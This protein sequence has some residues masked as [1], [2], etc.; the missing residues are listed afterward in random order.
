MGQSIIP[1]V[2]RRLTRAV[3]AALVGMAVTAASVAANEPSDWVLPEDDAGIRI[4]ALVPAPLADPLIAIPS[5]APSSSPQATATP[6]ATPSPTPNATPEPGHDGIGYDLSY[7]QCDDDYPEQF[8]FAIVGVNGGRVFNRNPCFGPGDEPSQLEWAG[9]DAE[10]YFN[11]GNPGPRISRYW[12]RGQDEPRACD[13]RAGRGANRD[14]TADCAFVYGWNAAEFAHD[15][16]LE[17]FIDLGWAED[18]T[19]QL[20]G[21]TTIWLDVEP[22]NSWRPDRSLNVATLEGAVAYLEAVGVERIGFY[23]T[24]RLW[25]RI[26]GG[27]DRF[28]DYPA[29]HAGARDRED[30]ERRC[31]DERAFTGGQLAMVQW[32][33]NGL[34]HNV[35]CEAGEPAS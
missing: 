30:A 23:S 6:T 4:P 21:E 1:S 17:A 12:P 10:L 27:T 26:T 28:G 16:A 8:A 11:T 14:D 24:P 22:A 5:P 18:G 2:G 19:A 15:S 34:D 7:P 29:W 13:L 20:P 35:R 31:E 9:P 33:E 25:D 3:S 32:V